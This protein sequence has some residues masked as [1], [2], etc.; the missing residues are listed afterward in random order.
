MLGNDDP[1]TS[2]CGE[3]VPKREFYDYV[4]KYT[5]GST[6]LIVPAAIPADTSNAI[7][8]HGEASVSGDGLCRH[9]TRGLPGHA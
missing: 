7:R 1:I 2:V 6:E 4:A 3:I 5:D 9:G 8:S